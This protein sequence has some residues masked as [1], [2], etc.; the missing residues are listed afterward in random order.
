MQVETLILHVVFPLETVQHT[1]RQTDSGTPEG[2][3]LRQAGKKACVRR[4]GGSQGEGLCHQMKG[5]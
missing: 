1:A 3:G 4:L 2:G 5:G